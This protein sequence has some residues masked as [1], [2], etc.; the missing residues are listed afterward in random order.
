[1]TVYSVKLCFVHSLNREYVY[2]IF[3][4]ITR[5][6]AN[7]HYLYKIELMYLTQN[8]YSLIIRKFL[9]MAYLLWVLAYEI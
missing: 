4:I 8:N 5:L 6:T 9:S 2:R 3:L 7:V 1:M